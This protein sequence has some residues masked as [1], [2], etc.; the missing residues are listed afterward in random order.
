[1]SLTLVGTPDEG[2]SPFDEIR[3]ED[4]DGEFWLGREL[5]PLMDYSRWERF[6]TV[7][8]KAKKSLALVHGTVAA[9]AAFVQVN[10]LT[11]AG[12]LGEQERCDYRLTR[13]GAYLTAMAGDD[14]KPAVAR[15]RVYFAIRTREAEARQMVKAAGKVP[16]LR[17]PTT[18]PLVD[19]RVL[20]R[21]NFGVNVAVA[22]LTRVLRQG[23]VLRQDGRP[24]AAYSHLFW[25]K[26]N[27]TYEVFEH[28]IAPLYHIYESTKL[29]LEMAAQ[30]ALRM[31]PPGWPEL[32][33]EGA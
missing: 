22:E 13:F 25:L 12:N 1:M 33:L 30:A 15:A 21:Q 31:D 3:H 18:Y 26:K 6:E 24:S 2:S 8:K 9:E 11:H 32:P 7:I 20:I 4:A 17:E 23:G 5:Q 28:S 16:E 14:T 27:G 19:V 10:Q 29:R